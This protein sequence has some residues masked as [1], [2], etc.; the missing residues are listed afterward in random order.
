[1]TKEE[2]SIYNR[3]YRLKHKDKHKEYLLENKEKIK[4]YRKENY[5]N[6]KEKFKEYQQNNKEKQ[7]GY[8]EKH[9][10]LNKEKKKEYA[11]EYLKSRCASDPLFKLKKLI[12]E[13]ISQSLKRNKFHKNTKTQ[14]ILGCSFI[15]F[16]QYLEKQ[17]E[18]WMSWDNQGLYNGELN[19][20]WDIDHIIPI[21]SAKTEEEAIKLSHFSNFQP[22]CSKVN[23]D[24]KRDNI[25]YHTEKLGLKE[26]RI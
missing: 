14:N 26:E 5:K 21:S 1:M 9:Y 16:K 10:N 6:N 18:N 24:I 20:G 12:R 17:F 13:N 3:E 7:K 23:R 2:I 15:E 19:Y 22:L 4:L 8:L 11:R 25:Y